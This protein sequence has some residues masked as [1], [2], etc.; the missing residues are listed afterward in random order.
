MQKTGGNQSALSAL[1]KALAAVE[2]T[3]AAAVWKDSPVAARSQTAGE[4]TGLHTATM[5]YFT[6]VFHFNFHYNG[7]LK[8]R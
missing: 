8:R 6:V 7:V 3:I 5:L 2:F 1:P 4:T